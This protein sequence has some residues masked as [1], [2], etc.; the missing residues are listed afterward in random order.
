MGLGTLEMVSLAEARDAALAAR[1]QIRDGIEPIHAKRQKELELR[2]RNRSTFREVAEMYVAAHKAGWKNAKHALQWDATLK[3]HAFPVLGDKP[4]S[5][6]DTGAVMRA[7]E[8]IWPTTAETASRLRGRIE[9]ILDYAKARGW[10]EGENP[11]RW[12]GHIQNLL[13]A[14]GKILRVR[15]HPALSWRE[16]A[17][18]WPPCGQRGAPAPE[19][20][21]SSSSPPSAPARRS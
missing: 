9:V 6:V 1:R 17:R 10:R 5:T 2:G 4:V 19:P 11:A 18:S 12:R 8:P 3:A 14:R 7:L 16:L 15:H 21:S 13:P 20:S